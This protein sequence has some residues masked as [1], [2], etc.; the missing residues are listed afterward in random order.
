MVHTDNDAVWSHQIRKDVRQVAGAGAN[1][2]NTGVWMEECEERATCLL[3]KRD[4][5]SSSAMDA[6]YVITY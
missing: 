6:Q 5:K 1:V 2:E 3:G 4:I